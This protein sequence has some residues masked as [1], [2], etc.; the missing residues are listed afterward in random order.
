[1]APPAGNKR[2][3]NG[4]APV[5]GDTRFQKVHNDPR[6]ARLSSKKNKL[7]IDKR[8]A[9]VLKDDRFQSVQGALPLL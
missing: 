3:G 8:F 9:A 5:V 7:Q 6:F 1:M 4:A 2:G